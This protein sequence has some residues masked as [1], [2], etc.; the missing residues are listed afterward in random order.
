MGNEWHLNF[1][2]NGTWLE[3]CLYF[4]SFR[5]ARISP[6]NRTYMTWKKIL[7]IY[8]LSRNG[9]QDWIN[10]LGYLLGNNYGAHGISKSR[11]RLEVGK[12]SSEHPCLLSVFR[13]S[14]FPTILWHDFN[15]SSVF[16]KICKLVLVTNPRVSEAFWTIGLWTNHLDFIFG[17]VICTGRPALTLHRQKLWESNCSLASEFLFEDLWKERTSKDWQ[18]TPMFGWHP[19]TSSLWRNLLHPQAIMTLLPVNGEIVL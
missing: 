19:P 15:K 12:L 4:M 2:V 8:F 16:F 5:L 9:L 13:A 18:Q 11:R 10:S 14:A 6:V 3:N 7:E 17:C 1:C